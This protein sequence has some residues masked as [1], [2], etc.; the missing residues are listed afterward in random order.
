MS[1]V[2]RHLRPLVLEALDDT[3]AVVVLGAR[4]VGKSTLVQDISTGDRPA[5]VLTLDDQATR[6]AA[7]ADP[8]GFVAG[9]V[10]PVVIDEVQRV[11]DLLLAIK[12]RVDRELGPG[13][14]LLTGSANI[15]T[16][17]R[18]PTRS[19]GER[20]TCAWLRSAKARCA[21]ARRSSHGS[22]RAAG[23]RSPA[24][25]SAAGPLP[26]LSPRVAIPLRCADAGAADLWASLI[27]D[28]R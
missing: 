12:V 2:E 25:P 11:P 17:P 15:L 23:R 1:I 20:S 27:S 9:L 28:C 7:A 24:R 18:I 13:Q 8:T 19:P 21:D 26:R 6:D 10:S 22:S 3:R 5:T 14:F 16:A 4:Q